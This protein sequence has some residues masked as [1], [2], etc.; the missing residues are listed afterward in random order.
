MTEGSTAPRL[1]LEVA[2]RS[3]PP[4]PSGQACRWALELLGVGANAAEAE[5]EADGASEAPRS[6][7]LEES[8]KVTMLLRV[9]EAQGTVD[10]KLEPEPEPAVQVSVCPCQKLELT[11]SV[12]GVDE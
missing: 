7:A 10:S 5:A 12:V 9:V 11:R 2:V 1:P 8:G 6:V 4:Q 3:W